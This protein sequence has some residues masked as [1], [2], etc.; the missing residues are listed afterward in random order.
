MGF[1]VIFLFM[2]LIGGVGSYSLI[3]IKNQTDAVSLFSLHSEKFGKLREVLFKVLHFNRSYLEGNL[4]NK[5]NYETLLFEADSSFSDL[6]RVDWF[7]KEQSLL[8]EIKQNYELMKDQTSTYLQNIERKGDPVGTGVVRNVFLDDAE[9][10][11][12]NILTL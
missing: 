8:Q 7:N 5:F 2:L 3:A 12:I 9:D 6:E 1:G 11:R 4:E 10:L